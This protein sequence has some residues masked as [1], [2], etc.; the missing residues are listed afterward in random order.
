MI[1]LSHPRRRPRSAGVGGGDRAFSFVQYVLKQ[2]KSFCL[3][4]A[5]PGFMRRAC[6]MHAVSAPSARDFK[7]KDSIGNQDQEERDTMTDQ[8]LT[9]RHLAGGSIFCPLRI[10]SLPPGAP[11]AL[12][13]WFYPQNLHALRSGA[14]KE[15]LAKRWTLRGALRLFPGAGPVPF[16]PRRADALP[17]PCDTLAGTKSS[18][19]NGRHAS[20]T[21][22]RT[23]FPPALPSGRSGRPPAAPPAGRRRRKVISLTAGAVFPRPSARRDASARRRTERSSAAVRA[24]FPWRKTP[25]GGIVF[26]C[27]SHCAPA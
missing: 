18:A 19:G 24:F 5:R 10:R 11:A 16:S 23:A 15:G 25:P 12:Q 7:G 21:A 2:R 1:R 20:R 17:P 22:C 4:E 9:A 14:G 6:R 8:E 26:R 3:R 27:F 13:T